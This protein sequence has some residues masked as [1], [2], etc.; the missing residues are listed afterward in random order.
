MHSQTQYVFSQRKR[1]LYSS[2]KWTGT[3]TK[4]FINRIQGGL[5]R[6]RRKEEKGKERVGRAPSPQLA[7]DRDR[8]LE[9]L[10]RR[11]RLGDRDGARLQLCR[12]AAAGQP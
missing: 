4:A 5:K 8:R 10:P 12:R 3:G 2:S 7:R 9:R 1:A 6:G 11:E